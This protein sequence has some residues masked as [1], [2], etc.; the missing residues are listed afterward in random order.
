MKTTGFPSVHKWILFAG[1]QIKISKFAAIKT[2]TTAEPLRI[3]FRM[4]TCQLSPAEPFEHINITH[5]EIP[6]IFEVNDSSLF[7]VLSGVVR[8]SSGNKV[9]ARTVT[10]GHL[11]LFPS[12][13]SVTVYCLQDAA[14]LICPFLS[15]NY[16]QEISISELLHVE[17]E[18]PSNVLKF[19]GRINEFSAL[20]VGYLADRITDASLYEILKKQLFILLRLYYTSDELAAFFDTV[21][22]KDLVFKDFILKNCL[23][24]HSL[25]ELAQLSNYSVS[26]FKKRFLRCFDSPPHRWILQYKAKLILHEIQ[27]SSK[28]FKEIAAQY[29]FCSQTYFHAFCSKHFGCSARTIR[30]G[31]KINP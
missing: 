22:G 27:S 7:F 23:K 21:I 2:T 13:T 20:I 4:Q 6:E 11:F 3:N 8:I 1:D 17:V 12:Q 15:N 5:S 9:F 28:P 30:K 18:Q 29:G 26:G 14:I 25:D 31:G 24:T 10:S 16:Y 19:R